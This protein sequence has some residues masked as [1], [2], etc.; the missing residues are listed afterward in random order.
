MAFGNLTYTSPWPLQEIE[1]LLFEKVDLQPR[2]LPASDI[3]VQ[4]QEQVAQFIQSW[5]S[6]LEADLLAENF[7]LDQSKAHRMA[8]VEEIFSKAGAVQSIDS[9][10][11]YNQLRGSFN[12]QAEHG[13]IRVFFTLSPEKNPKVQYLDVSFQPNAPK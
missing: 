3:L 2:K 8:E 9:I 7:Y 4:R 13:L 5:D 1:K 10:T 6:N 12:M 11:P